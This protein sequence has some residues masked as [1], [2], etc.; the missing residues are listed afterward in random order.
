MA[1]IDPKSLTIDYK[2]LLSVPIGDRTK[3]LR[4]GAVDSLMSALTPGQQAALFPT[5]YLKNG[6]DVG[7]VGGTALYAALSGAIKST[8]FGGGTYLP[9]SNA[10]SAEQQKQPAL[11]V[12]KPKTPE[13]KALAEIYKESG[14][15]KPGMPEDGIMPPTYDPKQGV[16]EKTNL[17]QKTGWNRI[18][19]DPY[20]P[21]NLQNI[22]GVDTPYGKINVRKDAA[23]AFS[24]FYNDLNDLGFPMKNAPGSFNI[25]QKRS[26]GAGHNPGQ[27]WSQ[28]SFANA[29][30]I[31]N[32]THFT[33]E[34]KRWL[35]KN[36]GAL[37]RIKAKWGMRSPQND[38][39]HIEFMG[40]ISPEATEQLTKTQLAQLEAKKTANALDSVS[41]PQPMFDPMSIEKLDPKLQEYYGKANSIQKM[42][43]EKAI[44]SL[45]PERINEIMKKQETPDDVSKAT[46]EIVAKKEEIAAPQ[47]EIKEDKTQSDE[48]KKIDVEKPTATPANPLEEATK[49]TGPTNSYKINEEAAVAAWKKANPG[50]AAAAA[51]VGKTDADIRA[52]IISEIEKRG[53]TYNKELKT[54]NI[55]DPAMMDQLKEVLEKNK[56]D[57]NSIMSPVAMATGGLKDIP[58][59]EDKVIADAKTGN[60]ENYI[61]SRES[62]QLKV[63]PATLNRQEPVANFANTEELNKENPAIEA[64]KAVPN[65][66][67]AK[68]PNLLTDIAGSVYPYSPSFERALS[69]SNETMRNHFGDPHMIR[70]A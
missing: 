48:G 12:E 61:N 23:L 62:V 59:G 55:D 54:L 11:N 16:P 31:G 43:F 14:L 18:S 20:S 64:T 52:D 19:G 32:Q 56:I 41:A 53:L 58:P 36:P 2:K 17:E 63:D 57:M 33:E 44:A 15:D 38:E 40:A 42:K 8:N 68:I 34:Q 24:G 49:P 65:R 66:E 46:A 35:E 69:R 27:G 9:T 1:T 29:T 67:V 37:E 21:E 4:S 51:F 26:A 7:A 10:P 39:P 47:K 70:G 50:W 45:G 3:L 60:V 6:M 13:E 28:H 25:R 5:Y 22:T 30:D